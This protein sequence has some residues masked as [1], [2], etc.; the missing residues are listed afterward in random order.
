VRTPRGQEVLRKLVERS[1]ALI[2]NLRTSTAERLGLGYEA[3]AAINPRLVY[4]SVTA[5]GTKGPYKDKGGYDRMTQGLALEMQ[6]DHIKV[7]ALSPGGLIRTPGTA[8]ARGLDISEGFESADWMGR[9]AVWICEQPP[10]YTGNI[11]FDR[12][13]LRNQVGEHLPAAVVLEVEGDALLVRV[14]QDEE[15]RI[16]VRPLGEPAARGLPGRRLDLDDL[17]AEPAEQLRAARPGLVLREVE[18]ADAVE[19]IAHDCRS[20]MSCTPRSGWWWRA[21]CSP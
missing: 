5:Y 10:T 1:D 16:Q 3:L 17:C 20:P 4:A 6:D 13:E 18:N 2:H 12:D 8:F 9:E 14:E 19:C 11:L 21:P 15:V 7:N